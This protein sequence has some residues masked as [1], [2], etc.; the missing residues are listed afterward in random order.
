LSVSRLIYGTIEASRLKP[1][2]EAE[3][4]GGGVA[5]GVFVPVKLR[6][7][8]LFV[9]SSSVPLDA[10]RP[11]GMRS[12]NDKRANTVWQFISIPYFCV[13]CFVQ[14]C[15]ETKTRNS[16]VCQI[17]GVLKKGC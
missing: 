11:N 6:E 2:A 14:K 8:V 17:E 15:V 4:L 10:C 1:S 3:V 5:L 13:W 7:P 9:K 16:F 12:D